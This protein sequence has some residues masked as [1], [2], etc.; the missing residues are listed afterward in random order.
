MNTN[1]TFI[2]IVGTVKKSVE[3]ILTNV[4]VQE[5]LPCLA[6]PSRQLPPP[7]DGPFGDID[8]QHLQLAVNPRCVRLAAAIPSIRR[9]IS[10]GSLRKTCPEPAKPLAPPADGGVGSDVDQGRVR[11]RIGGR[12]KSERVVCIFAGRPRVAGRRPHSPTRRPN[13]R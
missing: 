9:R 4:V 12:R 3:T 6:G 11:P 5:C 1:G 7:G 10:T 13:G 8:A 2:V